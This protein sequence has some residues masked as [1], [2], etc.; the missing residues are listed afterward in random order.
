LLDVM[1]PNMNGIEVLEAM[2][3]E[4]LLEATPVV[5]ISAA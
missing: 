2:K 1:M 4:E 5:M 3:A